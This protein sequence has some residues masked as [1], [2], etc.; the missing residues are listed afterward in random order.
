MELSQDLC[1]VETRIVLVDVFIH[2][3]L[4]FILRT[5]REVCFGSSNGNW[6]YKAKTETQWRAEI[7][8]NFLRVC[9]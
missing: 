7:F 6:K 2:A 4:F 9:C 1:V 5:L 8:V 3:H